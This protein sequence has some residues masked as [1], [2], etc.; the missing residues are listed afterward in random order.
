MML[1][2][3]SNGY[4][5]KEMFQSSMPKVKN[6]DQAADQFKNGFQLSRN[7]MKLAG[8][9]E[10]VGSLFLMLSI[11]SRSGKTFIKIGTIL[12]NIILGG[13]IFKHLQGGHC[14]KGAKQ[15]LQVF[16][17]NALKFTESTRKEFNLN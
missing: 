2:R 17:L 14:I 4:V 13:A 15:A 11:L 10:L 5:A 16:S 9:F 12:I 8:F 6:D 3:V 7:A 1:Q